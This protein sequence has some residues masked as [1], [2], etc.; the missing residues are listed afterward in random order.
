MHLASLEQQRE[1]MRYMNSLNEWLG[2]DVEDRQAELR[3]VTARI[4][5]LRGDLDRLGLPRGPC[6][7]YHFYMSH[8]ANIHSNLLT[9]SPAARAW[10]RTWW[11]YN[12][13]CPWSRR[14][15]LLPVLHWDL[16]SPWNHLCTAAPS[17]LISSAWST[18]SSTISYGGDTPCCVSSLY[19][20]PKWVSGVSLP[21]I[22]GWR[23]ALHS[24]RSWSI[25]GQRCNTPPSIP[26]SC[27]RRR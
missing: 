6:K 19:A 16:C 15:R 17:G 7:L 12:A 13:G 23:C 9:F 10:S 14:S 24:S 18:I 8:I 25:P 26:A 27:S 11:F 22:A 3:G 21:S 1:L 20:N 5:E 2:H 4:D